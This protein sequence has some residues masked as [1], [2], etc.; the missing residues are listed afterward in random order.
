MRSQPTKAIVATSA[1]AALLLLGGCSA[2]GLSFREGGGRTQG[3]YLAAMYADVDASSF[4]SQR[5]APFTAP[6]NLAVAQ[7][8][9]ISPP[10]AMLAKLRE[11]SAQ[12][13][14]VEAIPAVGDDQPNWGPR[15]EAESS[16]RRQVNAL[17]NMAAS[18]GADYLLLVGGT[19][20]RTDNATP[21]SVLN[22]TIIGA[23]VVPSHQTRALMKAS[24]ALIDVRTGQVVSISSAEIEDGQVAPYASNEGQM[25]RLLNRMRDRVTV[26]LADAVAVDCVK[27]GE[28]TPMSD[29]P[30]RAVYTAP[31][32][33]PEFAPGASSNLKPDFTRSSAASSPPSGKRTFQ[34]R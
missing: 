26:A 23:F 17:R 34:G 13:R 2:S 24:G 27:V 3:S 9:E 28:A 25:A 16:S 14:R 7:V 33:A 29:A 8:G 21:F 1:T 15:G 31:H 30:S 22:L 6:A 18:T 12:F 32:L 4:G 19:V 5:R 11:H 20:D 10:A